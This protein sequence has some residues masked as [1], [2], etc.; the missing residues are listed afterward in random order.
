MADPG[1]TDHFPFRFGKRKSRSASILHNISHMSSL[2]S[3]RVLCESVSWLRRLTIC[4]TYEVHF[5]GPV[6][7]IESSFALEGIEQK[8]AIIELHSIFENAGEIASN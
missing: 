7:L 6:Y 1:F 3:F 4:Y 8:N 5:T 2:F